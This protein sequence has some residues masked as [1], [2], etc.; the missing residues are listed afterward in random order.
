MASLLP[1]L[2]SDEEDNVIEPSKRILEN[3][4]DNKKKSTKLQKPTDDDSVS[5]DDGVNEEFEFGGMLEDDYLETHASQLGSG[6]ALL[7]I[8]DSGENNAWSYKKTLELLEKQQESEG[9]NV[10]RVERTHVASIIAAVRKNILKQKRVPLVAEDTDEDQSEEDD[11]STSDE[12]SDNDES[13]E[14]SGVDDVDEEMD[15]DILKERLTS[16]AQ[17]EKRNE[18]R[19]Q[20]RQTTNLAQSEGEEAAVTNENIVSVD[21]E[22]EENEEEM[23]EDEDEEEEEEVDEE[24]KAEAIKA[25]AYFHAEEGADKQLTQKIEMFSQLNLSRPLLRGV[26]NMGFVSPTPIQARVIPIALAGRD[27]CASAVTGSG[28]TAAFL[29]PVMERI[30]QRHVGGKKSS[31]THCLILT[32]TRELAAQCVS[33]S[34][35]I[36]QFTKLRSALVVGGTKNINAQAAELRTRPDFVVGTPGRILDHLTNSSGVD[37]DDLEFL[38]L[39][40][41]DR[42]LDLGFQEEVHEI[43]KA[44][45]QERQT[46][47]FSATMSTNVDEL[48]RLSLKRP[49]RARVSD[50]NK[51]RTDAADSSVEVASRLE[52]EFV[53]VRSGNDGINREAMLIALI[54]RTFS[55]RVIVFFDTKKDAHRLMI[56]CGLSGIKCAELHGN[57]TQTQRL[58]ALEAFREGSVDVLLATDLAA[59]GLDISSVEVVINFEM[60]VNVDNYVHRIGRTAR[61]GRRGKA[62]TLISESRRQLM[63]GV[64]KDAEQKRRKTM[65]QITGKTKDI[66]DSTG[67]IRSRSIPTA[68]IT[69][70][71]A[72]I[73]LL[74]DK[75]KE[76]QQAEMVA[77][78]DRIVEMESMKA[79][80][81][82][83]HRDEILSRPQKEWFASSMQ[84]VST[85]EAY[86]LK[87]QEIA[88][89]VGTGKHRMTRKKRRMRE[90]K[91]DLLRHQEELLEEGGDAGIQFQNMTT[92]K[93]MK[94][95]AR[96]DKKAA[97]V[98]EKE[99]D[100]QSH[101]DEDVKR[102]IRMKETEKKKR[103]GAFASDSLGDSGLFD[104]EN[105]AFARKPK[106]TEETVAKTSYQF[107][108]FDP[109]KKLRKGGK[110]G[111]NRFKSKSKHKR[112]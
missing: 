46:L 63:K 57:L 98:R 13:D 38:I 100:T 31:S 95:S 92:E 23:D 56:I 34:M 84:K 19:R 29:L 11:Q 79:Q 35:A 66:D 44:C 85:Q 45:P 24:G 16:R 106:A 70:F 18:L 68:V 1:S 89:K 91:E 99:K 54:T 87:Q 73:G 81:M 17:K 110:K 12:E 8:P 50:K 20:R 43:V 64:M 60:P 7:S 86:K 67:L 15:D 36:A 80:N 96:A 41:A 58:E 75:I 4:H 93:S 109:N 74:E 108:D 55:K 5:S 77:K 94:S 28:K 59:R 111:S 48:I 78:L 26:A 51:K 104:D 69:H 107:T 49:V 103:K 2:S 88:D 14:D 6:S 52:Q 25:A 76:V 40:E 39:D 82:I 71:V 27:I 22:E 10:Q 42:L 30:L 102:K 62:C 21:E 53:R 32:P 105:I 37:F 3:H 65:D 47:L 9:G 101:F 61:I 83:E 33:M 72:K 112:R 90:A 97:E